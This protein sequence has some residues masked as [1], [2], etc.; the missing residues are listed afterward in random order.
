MGP[1]RLEP[2]AVGHAQLTGQGMQPGQFGF[3]FRATRTAHHYELRPWVLHRRQ[4]AD[5]EVD[6][7]QRLDPPH[8]EQHRVLPRAPV[9]A[10]ARDLDREVPGANTA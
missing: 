8:K 2:H 1:G 5:R 7:L 9:P 4:A 3:A 6:A 10:G